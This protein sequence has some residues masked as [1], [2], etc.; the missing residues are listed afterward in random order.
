MMGPKEHIEKLFS[1]LCEKWPRCKAGMLVFKNM[2]GADVFQELLHTC[3]SWKNDDTDLSEIPSIFFQVGEPGS[4]QTVE[5]T[6]WA[7][8][9]ETVEFKYKEYFKH[10]LGMM[11]MSK[12]AGVEE[13]EK[14]CVPA[15]GV[16]EY[17]TQ[18]NGPV[19][20]LGTSLFY[21]YTISYDLQANTLAIGSKQDCAQC[22]ESSSLLTGK[23]R[24]RTGSQKVPS[25]NAQRRRRTLLVPPRVAFYNTSLPL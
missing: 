13:T 21:E 16:M 3:S 2:T 6:P 20:I 4:L 17:T 15:F 22:S 9:I 10:L 5:I 25:G 8:V 19:W 23:R 14:V 12:A 18:L 7:Y 24:A 11:A 1:S